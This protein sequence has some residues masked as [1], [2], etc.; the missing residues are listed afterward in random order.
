[1]KIQ[2]MSIKWQIIVLCII[3]ITIPVVTLGVWSYKSSEKEIYAFVEKKLKEQTAMIVNHIETATGITQQKVNYDLQVAHDVLYSHGRPMLDAS[4]QIELEAMNQQTKTQRLLT[5]PL[6]KIE[7]KQLAYRYEIVDRI[8]QLVGGTATIFQMIP[9]GALRISTN[10][11]TQNNAR[12]VGTY[13]PADSPV[14]QTVMKG[15]TFY[16]RAYVVNAWYQTAYEPIKDVHGTVIGMLYVG[17][18]D[19]SETIFDSLAKLVVGKTGY[20]WIFNAEGE[21]I[22]S[23]KRQRDGENVI[24]MKDSRGRP[25]VKE[26]ISKAPTLKE[27]ESV[28]DYYPWI[29]IGEET[30]RTKIAAYTYFPKWKWIIGAS[31]Y[32]EDFQDSLKKIRMITL[33]VSSVAIILG[34]TVAYWLA[35]L[36]V[37]PLL[38]S[39]NFAKSISIGDLTAQIDVNQKDEAGMLANA[40]RN[41]KDRISEVL[42]ETDKLTLAVQEGRLD[43]RGNSDA[44]SGGWRELIIGINNVIDAFADPFSVTAEYIERISKGD[45]PEKVAYKYQGDFKTIQNNLNM[46]I[47]AMTEVSWIAEEIAEGNLTVT[48]KERSEHDRLMKAL[49]GMITALKDVVHLAEEIADGN[50]MIEIKE[51]SSQ[52]ALMLALN[53][54]VRQLNMVVLNVRS[55]ANNVTSGSLQLSSSAEI[56]SQGATEQAAAA[57]EASSSME[58]MAANIHQNADNALRTEKIAVKSA[59]DAQQGG[60]AVAE[61]VAAMREI[62]QKITIIED[63]S[64]QTRLLSLNATIEAARAQEHGKGFAVVAAEVRSLAEHS[65]IAAEEINELA[66]SSVAIAEKASELL[67]T[68]IPDSQKTAEL[69]QEI[70]AASGEQS[71]GA[72]QIN[73]AI[74]QL[75]QVIQKNASTSEEVASTAAELASLAEQLQHSIQFFKIGEGVQHP[76]RNS[77]KIMPQQGVGNAGIGGRKKNEQNF[78]KDQTPQVKSGRRSN[79]DT[80]AEEVTR[81][82]SDEQD[83]EFEQ[84]E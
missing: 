30:P 79:D 29:N 16:G 63:I 26:W 49:N 31:A 4:E 1:M 55:A 44:F 66:N 48:A 75:D 38:K 18:K 53:S 57:E 19:A 5:V 13:I 82:V 10:V 21:Y 7:G 2:N 61:T 37:K 24:D 20:V 50:L 43:T 76:K 28:V 58:Q 34:S 39:V 74:Q 3:L 64:S 52:D 71:T 8:Q 33:T 65:R 78:V 62:A 77:I 23:Y 54:M 73:G 25:F 35:L 51:R 67:A 46:L 68:I 60:R 32:I 56:L 6:L 41:M 42:N 45:I 80:L 17:V 40:L 27:G 83:D 84:Y 70:S 15:K 9:E 22:L 14:Y 12:A 72:E 47:D 59:Q 69:V 11:L 36:I 81:Q